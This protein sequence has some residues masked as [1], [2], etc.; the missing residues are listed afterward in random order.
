MFATFFGKAPPPTSEDGFMLLEVVVSAL[1]VALIAVGTLSGID[2][3]NR[4]TGDER[5][6]AQATVIAQQDEERLRGLTATKLAQLVSTT[7]TVAENGLCVEKVSGAWLYLSKE[8][9]EKS[10][11]CEQS[12]LAKEYVSKSAS[13]TIFTVTSSASYASAAKEKLACETEKGTPDYIQT[14]SSVTWPTLGSRPAV[15]QSSLVAVPKSDTLLARV[16]N[17]SNEPVSEATVKVDK[18]GASSYEALATATT[19]ASGCVV[20]GG[21]TES[22]VY[23]VAERGN[24][25]NHNGEEPGQSEVKWVEEQLSTTAIT[26]AASF[27]LEAPGSI[28]AEFASNKVP[29]ESFTFA[30][31]QAEIS[32]GEMVGG[33]ETNTSKSYE[34]TKLF[35]F[36]ENKYTVY[37]GA[38]SANDP[39]EVS[40]HE[41]GVSDPSVQVEPNLTAKVTI[42][43]PAVNVTVYQGSIVSEGVLASAASA[44]IFNPE[45]KG[46]ANQRGTMPTE[47][48]V[49]ISNGELVQKYLPY[50]K[51]LELCVAA[52]VGGTYYKNKLAIA[53][54][55]KTGTSSLSL[56]LKGAGSESS[57]SLKS[58]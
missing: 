41:A 28:S 8:A 39:V 46:K 52:K 15:S 29:V 21:L 56:F 44:K 32:A 16:K 54:T 34:L 53:N 38:C 3:S 57:G 13:G 43:A 47:Y 22:K 27:V 51:K 6:H 14:T 40:G 11:A 58:C 36:K 2:A 7:Q 45:C 42:E 1:L 31:L 9:L 12:G 20:F 30:A 23:V 10:T 5:A 35:P 18:K 50:A 17:R 24:W 37:A 19:P 48:P 4:A 55:K 33:S 25:V 26:E 49:T